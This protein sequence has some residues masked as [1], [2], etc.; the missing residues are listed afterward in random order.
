VTITVDS[1][2]VDKLG[3]VTVNATLTCSEPF[4]GVE[5]S[6]SAL[7]VNVKQ[8]YKRIYTIFGQGGVS[9]TQCDGSTQYALKAVAETGKFASGIV[10]L[11]VFA[12]LC[13]INFNCVNAETFLNTRI[14]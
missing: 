6:F 10:Y 1:A 3:V 13:D 8:P 4:P 9:L 14:H 5:P 12:S 11:D 2:S 7:D